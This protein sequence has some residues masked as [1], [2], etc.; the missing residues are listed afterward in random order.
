MKKFFAVA[1]I[2]AMALTSCNNGQIEGGEP[3]QGGNSNKVSGIV[4][5][6]LSGADKYIEFYNTTD[7]M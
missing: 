7:A 6:E 4:L 2:A 3:N 5:N 1:A